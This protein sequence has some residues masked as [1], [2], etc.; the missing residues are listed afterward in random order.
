MSTTVRRWITATVCAG[1]ATVL[2]FAVCLAVPGTTPGQQANRAESGTPRKNRPAP[3]PNKRLGQEQI[4][5]I[6]EGE[7]EK[8]VE[9]CRGYLA[10]DPR[11]QESLFN[12]TLAYCRT[13]ELDKAWETMQRSLQAGLPPGR[14]LAGPRR[15]LRP[16]AETRRFKEFAAREARR[17]VHGPMLG[18]VTDRSAKFWVRTAEE[19][20]VQVLVSKSKDLDRPIKSPTVFSDAERDYTAVAEVE[21][22]Q[23]D[24][25]YYYDVLLRGRSG[26]GPG[27]PLFR[28]FP[29]AGAPARFR[30]AFG[31]G[32]GY[33]PKHER[34]WATVL[35]QRPL[36]FLFLGDNV[37]IDK[38][39]LPAMQQY[40]YY[41]RQSRPEYRRFVASTSI[42][43]IWDDHDF[44]T[45]DCWHGAEIDRPVWK[46]AVWRVFRDNWNNPAY[47]G[48]EKQPGCWFRFAIADVDFFMLDGRYY[49]SDPEGP[50]PSMLGRA[51]K[52][53]LLRELRHSRATFKVLAS[54]V[55]WVLDAKGKSLD[56]WRGFQAEREEIFSFLEDH[57][58]DGV[59][60]ISADRHRSDLWRIDRQDGYPL[61]EFESS[62]LT[63]IHTHGLVSGALF[64]Y[65]KKCSFG[66]LTFDTTGPDPEL[67]YRIISIDSELIHEFVVRKSAISHK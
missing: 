3:T 12:L 26:L 16:L 14:F 31:G 25:A 44:G 6:I 33:T 43:A 66:L 49:R 19:V 61:Y 15:L 58:I 9:L 41:R 21:G 40:T 65:N 55:P 27:H 56:T 57:R 7:P 48:G 2:S 18:C 10:V 17:L 46:P 36:A 11:H 53:W 52:A 20:P 13:G 60:L 54:P 8:A 47:G 34:M 1:A 24:T 45:N 35:R 42:F 62:R 59:V 30:V 22:L 4:L 64:G 38:P 28:T 67:S 51:Q 23:P 50:Q 32:A 5:P 37:Y 63:N 29:P 39:T